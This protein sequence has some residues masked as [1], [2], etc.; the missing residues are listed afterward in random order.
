E[1]ARERERSQVESRY[2]VEALTDVLHGHYQ[3]PE[4]MLARA[5]LLGYDLTTPQVVAIF[6]ALVGENDYF[7][8]SDMVQWSRRVRDELVRAWPFCWLLTE[9]RRVVA[10]LPLSMVE[11]IA[12]AGQEQD[13]L[14]FLRLERV[15]AR[16][17][18]Q[19]SNGRGGLAFSCGLGRVVKNL[20]DV[21]Q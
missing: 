4:E 20:Q 18:P 17:Q 8:S 10:L 14:A 12:G 11:E 15:Y 9:A 6:E 7:E 3:Q 13:D 21:P 19:K 1:V 5:R 2:Q 16:L